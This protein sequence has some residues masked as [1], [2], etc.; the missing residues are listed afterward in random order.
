MFAVYFWHLEGWTPTNQALMDAAVKQ[1]RTSRHP[2]SFA[3]DANKNPEDF[4]NS[5]WH[6]SWHM[7]MEAL[8][9]GI[10]TCRSKGPN[11]E[12]IGRAYDYAIACR[13]RSRTWKW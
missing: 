6:T 8:G 2:L 7:F 13:D 10:S 1:A 11:D 4:K 9:E 3:C 5:L 12:S